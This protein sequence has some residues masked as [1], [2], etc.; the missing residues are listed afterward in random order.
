MGILF[1]LCEF[2][3]SCVG[4]F[5]PHIHDGLGIDDICGTHGL[6]IGQSCEQDNPRLAKG[7]YITHE[8]RAAGRGYLQIEIIL[9][10]YDIGVQDLFDLSEFHF[11]FSGITSLMRMS[12]FLMRR[13]EGVMTVGQ[14]D[15]Q[16]PQPLH[17]ST[18]T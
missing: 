3:S 8:I 10:A 17:F 14:L 16:S 1:F 5:A 13:S 11:Q 7:Q 18:S 6:G 15:Q 9:S 4:F 2:K 12:P